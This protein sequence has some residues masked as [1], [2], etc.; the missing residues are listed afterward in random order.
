MRKD[1]SRQQVRCA[2][3]SI[4][5]SSSERDAVTCKGLGHRC[6]GLEQE[7]GS[8]SASKS[9]NLGHK[10]WLK[11]WVYKNWVAQP[12]P[13]ISKFRIDKLTQPHDFTTMLPI[14]DFKCD[15]DWDKAA[16]S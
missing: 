10:N 15:P 14:S 2:R 5:N 3:D 7:M 16:G 4:D 6:E 13:K 11:I 8:F 12:D 9:H 1:G